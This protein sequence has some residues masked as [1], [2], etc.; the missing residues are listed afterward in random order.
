MFATGARHLGAS[1]GHTSVYHHG[2]S[3]TDP[4]TW[5]PGPDFPNGDDAGDNFAALLTNG[6]VLV[7]GN[8]GRF[9]E[10]DG[11]N[12]SPTLFS[13]GGSLLVLPTGE[14][15]VGGSEVYTATGTYIQP[16]APPFPFFHPPLSAVRATPSS[17]GNSTD[18]HKRL[19][20]GDENETATNYPLVRIKNVA[21][22]HVF[23]AKTHDHSTMAVATGGCPHVH[24]FRCTCRNGDW[25]KYS[26]RGGERYSLAPGSCNGEL[27]PQLNV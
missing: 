26:G 11:T 24:P 18:C 6:K 14:V 1:T 15:I 5:I 17:A 13:N 19:R 21:T 12:F 20:I 3:P 27:A 23:Y 16:W 7:E 9:Y 22:G 4:G 10:F 25:T 2:A 8:S